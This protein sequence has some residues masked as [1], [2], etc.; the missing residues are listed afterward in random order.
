MFANTTRSLVRQSAR[1]QFTRSV[2]SINNN[3]T[4]K[5]SNLNPAIL[6]GTAAGASTLLFDTSY[7]QSKL[8]QSLHTS[9][10][11]QADTAASTTDQPK[12]SRVYFDISIDGVKEGRIEFELADDVVPKTAENFRALCTGEKGELH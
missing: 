8:G 7:A 11:S 2:V 9:S 6:L 4:Q 5:R 1:Q 10:I 3:K 12:R